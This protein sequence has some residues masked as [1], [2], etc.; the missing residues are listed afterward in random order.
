MINLEEYDIKPMHYLPS[1][2]TGD[3]HR[4]V[5]CLCKDGLVTAGKVRSYQGEDMVFENN[6]YRIIG[7]E[8]FAVGDEREL[9]GF[10]LL[11]KLIQKMY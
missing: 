4:M 7:V 11:L 8:T 10:N 3:E 6:K 9:I 2:F 1:S 5:S